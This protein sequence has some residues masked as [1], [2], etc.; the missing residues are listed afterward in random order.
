MEGFKLPER[1]TR[2]IKHDNTVYKIKLVYV[3]SK[4]GSH[5]HILPCDAKS[6]QHEIEEAISVVL[7]GNLTPVKTD[8]FIIHTERKPWKMASLLVFTE[9]SRWLQ[10]HASMLTLFV[11]ARQ[12]VEA[13]PTQRQPKSPQTESKRQTEQARRMGR[14]SSSAFTGGTHRRK[15]TRTFEVK[16]TRSPSPPQPKK[17]KPSDTR[18]DQSLEQQDVQHRAYLLRRRDR[19]PD[20]NE[21]QQHTIKNYH[22]RSQVMHLG[23]VSGALDQQGSE[24]SECRPRRQRGSSRGSLARVTGQ[25]K[26]EHVRDISHPHEAEPRVGAT[27]NVPSRPAYPQ[28]GA[29]QHDT[30]HVLQPAQHDGAQ[31]QLEE[32]RRLQRLVGNQQTHQTEVA[33]YQLQSRG[34]LQRMVS[35]VL[36]PVKNLFS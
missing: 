35:A 5:E 21:R 11:K 6:M 24:G 16:E 7:S 34:P 1:D 15:H 33:Q 26:Q 25:A 3:T 28:G 4:R 30:H 22:L 12:D 14:L 32:Q 10:T 23:T 18:Q 36:T 2:L 9:N 13:Q 8:H 17:M 27:A 31:Y 29:V 19:V 20:T